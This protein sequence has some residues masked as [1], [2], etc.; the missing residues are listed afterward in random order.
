MSKETIIL[1]IVGVYLLLTALWGIIAGG[2]QTSVSDYFLGS[3]KVPWWAVTFAIVAAE[4]S[5]LTFISIPGL[6]YLT[7]LNFLQ[8]TVGYLIGRIVVSYILL[9]R[10]F[11]GELTTAYS[12]LENRFGR[13]TRSYASIVFIFTRTAADGVRLF[14]TA[15]P[16]KLMLDISYPAAIL[17]IAG[18]TIIYTYTGGVKGVI[19]VDAFQMF[20]YLG[21]AVIS[22]FFLISYLPEGLATFFT[23]AAEGNKLSVINLGFEN[24]LAGFF[25]QPYTLIGGLIGGAFLS[26]ASHGT[27]QLVVQRL[28]ATKELKSGRKAIIGSG[29]I[30]IFQFA[31]FLIL[32]VMLYAFYGAMEMKSD[33]IFPKFILEELPVYISGIII[34]GLFAAAMSTL[35]G[36]MSSLASSTMFDLII[37]YSKKQRDEKSALKLS[38]LLTIF[39]AGMLSLSAFFFMESPKA[40]VELA[41]SIASFTYGGLLG[42]FLL[43]VFNKKAKQEDA[44]AGFTAGIFIMITVITLKLAAWTWFTFIGVTATLLIGSFL[45]KLGEKKA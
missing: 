33:E 18:V 16:L 27:D 21:G 38:R 14:A 28:L 44:L 20:V 2:K 8:V 34:A 41:L 29:V 43:G 6:A 3:D 7:N 11:E 15:I 37:P 42:T 36:S 13:K 30:V 40:V 1:L 25:S 10:Y 26:A 12:F 22:I 39:W 32:G 17:I 4:T 19:W 35:A 24:G 45:Q 31:I 23:V 5:T 9:P